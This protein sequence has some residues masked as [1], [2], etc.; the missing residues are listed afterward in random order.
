MQDDIAQLREELEAEKIRSHQKD[1]DYE[2][3]RQS[4]TQT[5]T[6]LRG[7]VSELTTTKLSH[8]STIIA[9]ENTIKYKFDVHNQH[10]IARI[11]IDN[12]LIP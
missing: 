10:E 2:A 12:A 1:L 11:H 3:L 9:H 8:E 6:E 4:T 7:V 5:I